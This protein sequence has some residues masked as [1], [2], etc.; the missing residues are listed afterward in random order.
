[1]IQEDVPVAWLVDVVGKWPMSEKLHG[2]AINP[3]Y[4][5]V[6]FFYNMY[7]E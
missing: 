5:N 1:M 2:L 3:A 7:I 6:P 4:P